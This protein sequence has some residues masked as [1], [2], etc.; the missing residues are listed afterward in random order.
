MNDILDAIQ[1]FIEAAEKY[2]AAQL[3]GNSRLVNRQQEVLKKLYSILRE[4]YSQHQSDI[5]QLLQNDSGYVRLKASVCLIPVAPE[6]AKQALIR[7]STE[8]RGLLGF[9]AEMTLKEWEKGRLK[10]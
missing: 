5:I 6:E 1:K 2:G 8:E 10:P 7:L 4:S 3:E 9:E